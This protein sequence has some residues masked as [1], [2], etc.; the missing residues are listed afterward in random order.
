MFQNN[1]DEWLNGK[2]IP[3]RIVQQHASVYWMV[4][5]EGE[6]PVLGDDYID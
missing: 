3:W 6:A 5:H 1:V 2:Y 4:P